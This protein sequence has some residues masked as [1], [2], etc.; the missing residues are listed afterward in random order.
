MTTHGRV[1]TCGLDVGSPGVFE[2]VSLEELDGFGHQVV[3]V[4]SAR[5]HLWVWC[6][7]VCVCVCVCVCARARVRVCACACACV[8]MSMSVCVCACTCVCVCVR[9][10]VCMCVCA[11]A[12]P[13]AYFECMI[14]TLHSCRVCICAPCYLLDAPAS[15]QCMYASRLVTNACRAQALKNVSMPRLMRP[16]MYAMQV[17]G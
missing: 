12:H 13:C 5:C 2:L 1:V 17:R 8:C 11:R 14:G 9:V 6:M 3:F 10:C 15:Q 4:A 7:C 16:Y